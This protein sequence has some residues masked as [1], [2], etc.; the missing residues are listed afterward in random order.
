MPAELLPLLE[1]C[2]TFKA[3]GAR[4]VGL[5][6][7]RGD[8]GLLQDACDVLLGSPPTFTTAQLFLKPSQHTERRREANRRLAAARYIRPEVQKRKR[9]V[10]A[11]RYAANRDSECKL[12]AVRYSRR[13]ATDLEFRHGY[14]ARHALRRARKLRATPPWADLAAIR[15][16]YAAC[17]PGHHVDHVIPL[18]HPEL[19]GLHVLGNLQHLPGPENDGKGNRLELTPAEVRRA[20]RD[21][22]AVPKGQRVVVWRGQ[23]WDRG[24]ERRREAARTTEPASLAPRPVP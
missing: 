18:A 22:L 21:G 1:G 10:G 6:Y 14:R 24:P 2:T 19:D 7:R 9:Q 23:T 12:A 5:G 3:V 16:F 15:A 20:I 8:A 4:M 13:Y 11:A 17:P